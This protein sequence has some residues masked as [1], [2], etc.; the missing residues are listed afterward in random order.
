VR[1]ES[2][3]SAVDIHRLRDNVETACPILN[4]LKKPQTIEG[5]LDHRS[6]RAAAAE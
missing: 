5:R 2:P 4:L 1:I 3:A 6:S